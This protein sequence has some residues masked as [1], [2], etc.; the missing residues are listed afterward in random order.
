MGVVMEAETQE[1]LGGC[2]SSRSPGYIGS[3]V[4]SQRAQ[5]AGAQIA[6]SPLCSVRGSDHSMEMPTLRMFLS[7]LLQPFWNHS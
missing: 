2:Y 4:R 3:A 1:D 6:L 7:S 5:D